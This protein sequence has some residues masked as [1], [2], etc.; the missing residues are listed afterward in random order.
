LRDKKEPLTQRHRDRAGHILQGGEHL[1]RLIDDVLDLARIEAGRVSIASATVRVR[2]VLDDVKRTLEPMATRLQVELALAEELEGDPHV[3]VDRTRYAQILI[4]FGSNAIKYN[5][6]GGRVAFSVARQ[7][8]DMLRVTVVDTGIGIPIDKQDK[9]FQPFQRAGQETGPIEGT[10]IGLVITQRLAHMMGGEVG[11]QSRAGEGSS[12]WVDVPSEPSQR[13]LTSRRSEPAPARD[14]GLTPGS[15]LVLYVED[16]PAN[17]TFMRDLMSTLE[18]IDLMCVSTA[19]LGIE[20]ARARLPQAI[21]MDINLPG[22]SGVEALRV[23]R[24]L[25]E[26]SEIPVIALTAAASERDRERGVAA[27]FFRYLTK[28][29]QVA[30][31]IESLEQLFQD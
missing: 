7:S 28:P 22:M 30:E 13:A 19:E 6:P 27:G 8:A 21:L 24:S 16:N 20:F 11:F 31:L 26:T 10:G 14:K 18:N 15:R 12:F 2:D 4:N 5:K 25:P 23:L 29:V 9:L 3:I 17:V 1:L